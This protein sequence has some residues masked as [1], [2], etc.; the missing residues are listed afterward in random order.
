MMY[1][2]Y[3]KNYVYH[4]MN[5]SKIW[6]FVYNSDGWCNYHIFICFFLNIVQQYFK[7]ENCQLIKALS[8]Y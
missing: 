8:Y 3:N 6:F 1:V 2:V 7:Q 4:L 5:E